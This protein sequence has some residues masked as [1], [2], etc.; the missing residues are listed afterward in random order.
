[1]AEVNESMKRLGVSAA[2]TSGGGSGGTG[3][4]DVNDDEWE[5][6]LEGELN[7][8]EVVSS[9]GGREDSLVNLVFSDLSLL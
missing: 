8:F 7:E 9:T 5:A 3:G 6:E 1:M 4:G 2:A